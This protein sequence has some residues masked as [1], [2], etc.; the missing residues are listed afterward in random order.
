MANYN[1]TIKKSKK[2]K[3]FMIKAVPPDNILVYTPYKATQKEIE[4][5]LHQKHLWIYKNLKKF[6]KLSEKS[7][8]QG[9]E[10]G[11]KKYYLGNLYQLKFTSNTNL[12]ELFKVQID[13]KNL[14]LNF[15][16]GTLSS[17]ESA[18]RLWLKN[19]AYEIVTNCFNN[20]YGI[21]LQHD[22][23]YTKF[24]NLNVKNLKGKWG[25][26]SS[27][28]EIKLSTN[29]IKTPVEC[30]NYVCMHE[31]THLVYMNHGKQ[32]YTVLDN[33]CPNRKSVEKILDS[34]SIILKME[35]T[36]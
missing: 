18:Y 4:Q 17:K 9:Y 11:S 10:D 7:Q 14:I 22:F 34:F 26:C 16:L 27:R 25:V 6:E 33:L 35:T 3:T 31:L 32:F 36:L 23:K 20:C 29:L 24:K 28:G 21:F 12:K 8:S 15:E 13:K 5:I 2:R 19:Q 30:I 1:L